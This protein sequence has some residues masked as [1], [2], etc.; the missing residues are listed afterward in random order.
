MK[1]LLYSECIFLMSMLTFLCIVQHVWFANWPFR[2]GI[3]Q[4]RSALAKDLLGFIESAN[5]ASFSSTMHNVKLWFS[6]L[7]PRTLY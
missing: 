6:G 4:S 5:S 7:S 2:E 1:K 3:E